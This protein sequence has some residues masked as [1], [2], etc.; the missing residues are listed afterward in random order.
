MIAKVARILIYSI[1]LYPMLLPAIG[2]GDPPK[3][4]HKGNQLVCD[5]L[6]D[7]A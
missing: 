7:F 2:V 3:I 4:E 1:Y 5:F 6:S